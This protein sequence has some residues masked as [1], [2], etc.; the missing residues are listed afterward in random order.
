MTKT[1]LPSQRDWLWTLNHSHWKS[2]KSDWLDLDQE[3]V[4]ETTRFGEKNFH[5]RNYSESFRE[6]R[7]LKRTEK[8][9]QKFKEL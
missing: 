4:R 9:Q 2:K 3:V 1:F 6:L 7:R 5:V 8:A